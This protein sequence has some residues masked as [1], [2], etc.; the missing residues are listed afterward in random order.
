MSRKRLSL[1]SVIALGVMANMYA[2]GDSLSVVADTI[3]ASSTA[4][5]L[6]EI[7]K[8]YQET[9]SDGIGMALSAFGVVATI[10]VVLFL[11]VKGIGHISVYIKSRKL[12]SH[13]V[14]DANKVAKNS[15]EIYAAIAMA[16]YELDNEVHDWEDTKLTINKV[17]KSYSPWSSKIYGL[18]EIPNKR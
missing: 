11:I 12:S 3:A 7:S 13:G 4:K 16:L 2:A 5:P 15:G 6:G 10:L 14:K 17:A 8:F 9:D 1:L 18:R